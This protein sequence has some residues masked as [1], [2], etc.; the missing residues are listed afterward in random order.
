VILSKARIDIEVGEWR[1]F[2]TFFLIEVSLS[3][4]LALALALFLPFHNSSTQHKREDILT[5][6]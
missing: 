3:L 1:Y 6:M 4:A 2:M 5:S